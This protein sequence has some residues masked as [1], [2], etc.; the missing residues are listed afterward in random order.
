MIRSSAK[1]RQCIGGLLELERSPAD[2]KYSYHP[3]ISKKVH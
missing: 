2:V 1:R 3:A